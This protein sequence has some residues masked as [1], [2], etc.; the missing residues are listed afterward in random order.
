MS[1]AKQAYS[2]YYEGLD[3]PIGGDERFLWIN[4]A[5]L[6]DIKGRVILDVGCGEGTLLRMLDI[7]GNQVFG[8]DASES[9]KKACELKGIECIVA[10]MSTEN[11]SRFPD[12]MFDIVLCLET[13]EHLENPFH[14]LWEIK[15]LLKEN[16]TFI[17][18]IP[19]TKTLHPYVY[20]GLFNLKNFK[21]FLELNSFEVISIRGWGQCIMGNKIYRQLKSINNRVAKITAAFLY[22][23]GR[24]RN[25][26]MRNHT[27][28]PLKYSACWNFVCTNHKTDANLVEKVA[29]KTRQ[30][31]K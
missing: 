4:D 5:L 26:F 23:L 31:N 16:G 24:K 6:T 18:S 21:L 25:A 3:A 12:G 14:C 28:T 19:N 10:D 9:A 27:G 8:I 7:K 17:V 29:E 1:K 13:I 20:P 22:Y 2:D 15:R 30:N 11:L